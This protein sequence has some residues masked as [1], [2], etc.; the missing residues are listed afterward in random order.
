MKN[1]FKYFNFLILFLFIFVF[2]IRAEETSAELLEKERKYQ[3]ILSGLKNKSNTLLNELEYI[4]NQIELTNARIAEVEKNLGQKNMLLADLTNYIEALVK[5]IDKLDKSMGIQDN[6][7]KKRIVERYKSSSELDLINVLASGNLR[8]AIIKLQYLEELEDQD[9]KIISY[10]KDTKTDYG[11]QQKLIE[12]KREE[13]EKVKKDIEAQKSKL[14]AY[15]DSLNKQNEEKE[16]LLRLTQNDEAKYQRLLSQIQAELDA[17]NIAVGFE[18]KEGKRVKK[19]EVIGYLGNTGCSTAPH[20]HFAY[21]QGT[22]SIDP[23]PFLKGGKLGWPV[24][25]YKIT[26]YYG[27][28]Y[29]FYMRRF[30]VPGHLALDIVD[31]NNWIGSPILA[32]K[33]GVLHFANDAKVYCPDINNSIGKGAV[34]DHGGGEKTI[35]WH[36]R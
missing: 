27:E 7:M 14:I 8:T 21:M 34:I 1:F 26:Q 28:N 22:K 17:Q 10:M 18:G 29:N 2:I 16:S 32:A 31:P 6:A 23:F 3:E 12:K 25:N 20:L 36:L 5:R 33:D 30:G 35:Y 19:G 24:A 9:R 4:D 13:V 15:Q 11:V